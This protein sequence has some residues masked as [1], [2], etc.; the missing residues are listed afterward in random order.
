MTCTGIFVAPFIDRVGSKRL[1]QVAGII[2]F[3][4]YALSA[5]APNIYTLFLSYGVLSGRLS[6]III[7]TIDYNE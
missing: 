4:G 1:V 5:C 2:M 7:A 6:I 3:A